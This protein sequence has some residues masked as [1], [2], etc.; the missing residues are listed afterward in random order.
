MDLRDA[1]VDPHGPPWSLH[2]GFTDVH[3]RPWSSIELAGSQG[4]SA[5]SH[6]ANGGWPGLKQ[7]LKWLKRLKRL[8]HVNHFNHW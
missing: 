7:R 1:S 3:G 2:G 8:S 6:A 4:R 5:E